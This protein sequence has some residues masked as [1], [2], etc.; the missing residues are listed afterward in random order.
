MGFYYDFD[1]VELFIE[2][3]LKVIKKEMV[4]IIN[5]KLL[6]IWEEISWE[7]VK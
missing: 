2:V 4:K 1:V 5:K 3:D 7:E 6:V